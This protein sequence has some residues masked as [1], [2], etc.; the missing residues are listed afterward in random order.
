MQLGL[1]DTAGDPGGGA[2][3][4]G[5]D[6]VAEGHVTLG[7]VAGEFT[8]H[9]VVIVEDIKDVFAGGGVGPVGTGGIGLVITGGIESGQTRD[10]AAGGD[11]VLVG[12]VA[13]GIHTHGF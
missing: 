10:H 2:A 6:G 5:I 11:A 1:A 12:E 9:N 13:G 3:V 4:L 8:V 7:E